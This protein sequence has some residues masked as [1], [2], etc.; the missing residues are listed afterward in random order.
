MLRSVIRFFE[1]STFHQKQAKF[2]KNK[3][4]DLKWVQWLATTESGAM[5]MLIH[6]VVVL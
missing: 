6:Y 2:Q 3:N 5:G 4:F 1:K